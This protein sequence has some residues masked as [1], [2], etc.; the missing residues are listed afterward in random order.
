VFLQIK[1]ARKRVMTQ[2][3]LLP[4]IPLAAVLLARGYA[5]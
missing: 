3:H 2:A 1:Q 5:L 4:L